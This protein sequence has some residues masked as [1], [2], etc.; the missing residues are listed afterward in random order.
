MI[1][2]TTP[3]LEFALP[4]EVDLIAEAY[5]T[6]SQNQ[7]VV[8]DKSLSELT[9]A[10]KTLTVKLSQE[11]TLKLQQSEFKPAEVQIRV[12]MKSG[13][14]LASDIMRLHVG[15]ILKERCDLM[16]LE[17]SFRVLNKNLDVDFSAKDK[18]LNAEFQCFQRITEQGDVDYYDGSY[19]VTPKVEEQSLPT[20]KKYLAEDVRI[21]E[22]PIFEVS[23]LEGGQTVFIGKEI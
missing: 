11:D 12:R 2:G 19:T 16:R 21:K 9:C 4:F 15:R 1:R 20:S 14:A 10:G 7:S 22:I 6:I 18:K 8:I 17:V 3:T 13:D 5:V 23:N